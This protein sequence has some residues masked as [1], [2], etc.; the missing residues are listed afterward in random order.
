M[1][2]N[3]I[4]ENEKIVDASYT[5]DDLNLS[6]EEREEYIK[7][8]FRTKEKNIVAYLRARGYKFRG[9]ERVVI[10]NAMRRTKTVIQFCFDGHNVTRRAVLEYYN[11]DEIEHCNV[12]AK[13]VL[14]E[15]K[16]VN[17]LIANF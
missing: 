5:L 15:F 8:L 17:S 4:K 12:N 13:R 10:M 7:G 14:Q 6:K 2:E 1:D 11:T 9:M 16:N 3:S